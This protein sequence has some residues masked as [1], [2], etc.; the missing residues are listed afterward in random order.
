MDGLA[1]FYLVFCFIICGFGIW[2]YSKRKDD[3]P[4][5]IGVAYGIFTIERLIVLLSSG[6]T[7]DVLGIV[8]RIIAYLL[9]LFALYKALVKK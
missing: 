5:Y 8:L 4:L 9:V 1:I 7:L 6:P 2:V 3:V